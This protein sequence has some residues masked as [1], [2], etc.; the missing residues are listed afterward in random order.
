MS[1][2]TEAIDPAWVEYIASHTT[3]EDPFLAELKEAADAAGI[4]RIWVA[5]E[6]GAMLQVLLRIAGARRVVEVGT[7]A[8]YSAI[9]MARALPA[10]GEV[11]TIELETLHADFA[12]QWVARSDVAGKVRVLRG[13][14]SERLPELETGSFDACFIDADKQGYADYLEHCLRLLRPGGLV[15]VDNAF[16]FGNLLADGE[17][18]SS[19]HAI[20]SFNEAMA[21]RSDV[22]A[23]IVPIGDGCWV[24]AK[25]A[26]APDKT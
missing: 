21:R 25:I 5:P 1:E 18:E 16:A 14:G 15:M 12:E 3:R 2:R 17:Q 19:V 22:Q 10:D 9:N 8:G 13:R 4:P 7:L 24:G 6:Q 26:G 11:V 23:L 20:R